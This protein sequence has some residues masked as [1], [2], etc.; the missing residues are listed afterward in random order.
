MNPYQR[1]K[2]AKLAAERFGATDVL[3]TPNTEW[4]RG[5]PM[6]WFLLSLRFESGGPW[7]FVGRRQFLNDLVE[8]LWL[9]DVDEV[10]AGKYAPESPPV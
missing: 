8:L 4:H 7:H 9:L 5:H 1:A 6:H 3:I 10:R 2:I